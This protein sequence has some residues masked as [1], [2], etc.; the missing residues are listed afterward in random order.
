MEKLFISLAYK[1]VALA[2][3]M[4]EANH[5]VR[6]LDI[7][8]W[9]P[10]EPSGVVSYY[11][12]PPRLLSGGSVDTQTHMFGFGREGQLQFIHRREPDPDLSIEER[13]RRWAKM[14]SLIGTNEAYQLATNW[15]AKLEVDVA[16]LEKTHPPRV[17]QEYYY[18]GGVPSADRIVM[19][20]RYEVKWGTNAAR[21]AVWISMFGPTKEPIHIRQENAAFSRRPKGLVKDLERL[22]SISN[23]VF[24]S[25]TPTQKS[26]L[27]V[28][29]A[30]ARYPSFTLP[31][32]VRPKDTV[33]SAPP[34][35]LKPNRPDWQ[36]RLPPLERETHKLPPASPK[37]AKPH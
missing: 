15:L 33:P 29:S 24:A 3:M 26:N 11:I 1:Y 20:P 32:V 9:K 31:E 36:G 22:L 30:V 6:Q 7:P 37:P 2:L 28:E 13:H 12:A 14:K 34:N 27:V 35:Q 19:L 4:A 17:T 25:Y 5:V 10:V 8:G 18:R 16:A 21:P 23:Q